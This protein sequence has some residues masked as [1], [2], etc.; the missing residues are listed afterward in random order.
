MAYNI[1]DR[2][3]QINLDP[4]LSIK[5]VTEPLEMEDVVESKETAQPEIPTVQ[6][7]Q[8]AQPAVQTAQPA[9]PAQPASKINWDEENRNYLRKA[10]H[11]DEEIDRVLRIINGEE[12]GFTPVTFEDYAGLLSKEPTVFNERAAKRGKWASSLSDAANIL[13]GSVYAAK[14]VQPPTLNPQY[15]AINQYNSYTDK[16]REKSEAEQ[17]AYD[18]SKRKINGLVEQRNITG[19]E[20][21][22]KDARKAFQQFGN[23]IKNQKTLE[24]KYAAMQLANIK[25]QRMKIKDELNEAWRKFQMEN[26]TLNNKIQLAK[27][28]NTKYYQQRNLELRQG[29]QKEREINNNFNKNYKTN[30]IKINAYKS[31]MPSGLLTSPETDDNLELQNQALKAQIEK[32]NEDLRRENAEKEGWNIDYS[33]YD[34]DDTPSV[35]QET[36]GTAVTGGTKPAQKKTTN[37]KTTADPLGLGI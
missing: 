12:E 1:D 6:T 37:E 17:D 32:D 7:A 27:F 11:S 10:A 26:K 5:T 16:M 4:N 14:G 25:E 23:D 29:Q 13:L 28:Q 20:N 31:G 33:D 36:K 30:Q 21:A 2:F 8:P 24:F 9:Q 22:L 19:K 18:A 34:E 15:S 35:P 3:K